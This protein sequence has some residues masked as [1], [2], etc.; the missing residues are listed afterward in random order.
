VKPGPAQPFPDATTLATCLKPFRLAVVASCYRNR[1]VTA[2]LTA[3]GDLPAEEQEA[4][5]A[6]RYCTSS[7]AA[8]N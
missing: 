2:I 7:R 8:A 3:R 4:S 6:L 5:M 1:E